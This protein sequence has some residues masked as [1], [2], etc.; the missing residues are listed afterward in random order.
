VSDE[1]AG[2]SGVY[3]SDCRPV[4]CSTDALNMRIAKNVYTS[5]RKLV[6]LD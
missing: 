6:G 3:F 5:T 4:M 1:C 2:L